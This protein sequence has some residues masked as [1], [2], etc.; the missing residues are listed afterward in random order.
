[1][2]RKPLPKKYKWQVKTEGSTYW[3][4]TT[5]LK[6]ASMWGGSETRRTI[7]KRRIR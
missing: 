6:H 2:V 1:M 4:P 3:M 7:R 5:S